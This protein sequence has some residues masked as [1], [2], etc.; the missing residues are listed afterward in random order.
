MITTLR[1][2]DL[3]TG[4]SLAESEE[5]V[6]LGELPIP[7]LFFDNPEVALGMKSRVRLVRSHLS[8]HFQL[9]RDLSPELYRHYKSGSVTEDHL[10]HVETTVADLLS[11]LPREAHILEIGG[12]GGHLARALVRQG[13]KNVSV[14]DPSLE[15]RQL[16]DGYGVIT[17]VFPGVIGESQAR[18]DLIVAQ[19]FLEHSANPLSTLEAAANLLTDDGAI[20][21]EVPDIENSALQCDSEWLSMIYALHSSYFDL[22]SLCLLAEQANL[23]VIR[24]H[25]EDHYGKSI[26]VVMKKKRMGQLLRTSSGSTTDAV[27]AAIRTYFQR[28]ADYGSQLP[29]GLLCWGA[30]ERCTSLLM[31]SMAGGFK[32]GLICDSNTDLH[33]LFLAGFAAPILNPK[34]VSLPISELLVLTRR[35]AQAIVREN[36]SLF[37]PDALIYVP[38]EPTR[39]LEEII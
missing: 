35:N 7:G 13:F 32:P 25:Y 38:L 15:N 5:I 17:D 8:G 31:A 21:I 24:H 37:A 1:S 39:R 12:G 33:G 30:A 28:L 3:I 2:Y 4:E 11:W 16:N 36:K 10:R 22:D 20:L 34:H 14:I 6:D 26:V 29:Q 18:F 27:V 9:D 23:E 19:H